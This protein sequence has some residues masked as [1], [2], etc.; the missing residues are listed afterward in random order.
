MTNYTAKTALDVRIQHKLNVE[1][2]FVANLFE[3]KGVYPGRVKKK[4]TWYFIT[5]A[6]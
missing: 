1:S 2:F 4:S 6:W 3:K 5:D